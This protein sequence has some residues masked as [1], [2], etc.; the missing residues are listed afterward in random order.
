M[1][2]HAIPRHDLDG[3]IS[4]RGLGVLDALPDERFD[5][6]ARLA[7]RLFDLPM[8]LVLLWEEDRGWPASRIDGGPG[9]SWEASR[10]ILQALDS[11]EALVVPDT[12]QDDRF[13]A[14][15]LVAG[16]D[17]IRFFAAVPLRRKAGAPAAGVLAVLD[18]WP[19][20]F[21]SVDVDILRD[22]AGLVERELQAIEHGFTDEATGLANRRAFMDIGQKALMIC[23]RS[24]APAALIHIELDAAPEGGDADARLRDFSQRLRTCFRSSDVVA[25]LGQRRF[26]A[27]VT[28]C[29]EP[30]LKIVVERLQHSV[31]QHNARVPAGQALHFAVAVYAHVPGPDTA[32]TQLIEQAEQALDPMGRAS[33]SFAESTY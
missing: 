7:R 22:L 28:H 18:R 15:P 9:A 27:L 33:P 14:D 2:A 12:L 30:Y 11:R 16:D 26:V 1:P 24:H 3:L 19:R 8:A 4:L 25:R 13:A 21:P 20:V 17:R 6:V 29:S 32:L 31:A 23:A 5:R 10:L